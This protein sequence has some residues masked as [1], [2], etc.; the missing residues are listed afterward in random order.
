MKNILLYSTILFVLFSCDPQPKY[1]QFE[2]TTVIKAI[3][4]NPRDTISITDTVKIRFEIPDSLQYNGIN[5]GL[6]YND[7]ENSVGLFF[8]KVEKFGTGNYKTLTNNTIAT[9]GYLNQGLVLYLQKVG[10]KLIG[11]YAFVPKAKGIYFIDQQDLGD[12]YANNAQYHFTFT[13]DFGNVNR[14]HK[15]LLDSIGGNF[16]SFLQGHLDQGFEVYGFT[17]K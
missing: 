13:A 17:V 6:Y 16:N 10:K 4:I 3:V 1:A 7:R 8:S 5:T 2:G 14:N 15:L 12:I 9:I 11:E